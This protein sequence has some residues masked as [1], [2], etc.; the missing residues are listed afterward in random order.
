[1]LDRANVINATPKN[2]KEINLYINIV[3]N[4]STKLFLYK[5]NDCSILSKT[6]AFISII[7]QIKKY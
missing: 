5:T 1:M 7:V 4:K 3:K 2:K 6:H